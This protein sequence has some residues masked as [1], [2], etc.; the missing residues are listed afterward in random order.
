MPTELRQLV[1]NLDSLMQRIRNFVARQRAFAAA[2]AHELRTPL[3]ACTMQAE[4]AQ[5]SPDADQRN[6]ALDRV[7]QTVDRMARLVSQLLMLARATHSVSTTD[8]APIDLNHAAREALES[9]TLEAE[10]A[11]V[12]LTFDPC[13]TQLEVSGKTE[14]LECLIGNLVSNAISA[15]PPNSEIEVTTER[16][17]LS[18]LLTVRD[19]GPGIDSADSEH[20]FEPFYSEQATGGKASGSGLGLSIV[21]AVVEYHHGRIDFIHDQKQGATVRVE[22]PYA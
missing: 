2:A 15:S 12:G 5:R 21:K 4:L 14:L 16:T 9:C 17:T 19:Q 20:L 3:A 8:D 22:L 6:R 1:T 11:R 10:Q 13:P 18:A 7:H